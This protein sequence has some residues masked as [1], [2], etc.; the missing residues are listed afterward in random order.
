MKVILLAMSL[1][2]QTTTAVATD[3]MASPFEKE[4]SRLST[5]DSVE[6]RESTVNIGGLEYRRIVV[7][8]K[9]FYVQAQGRADGLRDI[10]CG[11]GVIRKP[12]ENLVETGVQITKRTK[13]Y[14][15]FL[16][17]SCETKH[18]VI[19]SYLLLEPEIGLKFKDGPKDAIKEKKLYVSPGA[20]NGVGFSGQW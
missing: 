1:L 18:G 6:A 8:K 3:D 9:E 11:S 14:I 12:G 7:G 15:S 20:L 13:A 17:E 5:N 16:Q 2:V 10:H 19:Q 4:M